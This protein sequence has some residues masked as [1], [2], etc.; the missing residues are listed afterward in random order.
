M[1]SLS[2]ACLVG[3]F[4]LSTLPASFA[5]D[6]MPET[7]YFP[8]QVG[9]TWHYKAGETEFSQKVAKHE[10]IDG[11]LCARLETLVGGKPVAFEHVAVKG[12]GVYR[13]TLEGKRPEAPV[14]FLKLPPKKGD[15]WSVET[16][17]GNKTV[18]CTFK[19][20]EEE[21]KVPAGTFQT[22]SSTSPDLEVNGLKASFA[23]YF[24][25]DVGMVKQVIEVSGQKKV[26]IELTKF[27]PG[28]K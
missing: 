20:D 17:A 5:Q 27:E 1:K 15:S 23:F 11:V 21:V 2:C 3:A 6:K 16:R 14:R 13:F 22:I 4:L 8:L 24:A 12:D 9:N 28:K 25:K 10:M 26:D 19:S 18:K 7:P